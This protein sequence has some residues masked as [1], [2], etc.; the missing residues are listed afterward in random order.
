MP[1][2]PSIQPFR[3][4][5][6]D[7]VPSPS[8]CLCRRCRRGSRRRSWC[9]RLRCCQQRV[10]MWR[11]RA[12]LCG[13]LP[14]SALFRSGLAR[15]LLLRRGLACRLL[16]RHRLPSRLLAQARGGGTLRDHRR[17]I[18]LRS[19]R[20]GRVRRGGAGSRRRGA[21]RVGLDLPKSAKC[22]Q[23]NSPSHKVCARRRHAQRRVASSLPTRLQRSSRPAR[24]RT[25]PPPPWPHRPPRRSARRPRRHP[26]G[27]RHPACEEKR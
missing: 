21:R 8:E 3:H 10:L 11:L 9:R 19:L 15:G 25:P 17:H 20:R 4:S 12:A 7:T 16:L 26:S 13:A 18:R 2:L 23:K 6:R 1:A 22:R 5:S 24:R 27:E 14:R